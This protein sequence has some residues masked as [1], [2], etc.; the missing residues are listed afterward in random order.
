MKSLIY[1][2]SYKF[3]D[4]SPTCLQTCNCKMYYI[5]HK[6][7]NPLIVVIHLGTD[8]H[9][10]AN[11]KCKESF[12]DMKNMVVYEVCCMLTT[13]ILAI[14]L[15]VSKTFLSY[16][17]FNKGGKGHVELLKGEKLN[18]ILLKFGAFLAYTI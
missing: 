12:Q 17:L 13:I 1:T 16:H 18:Q 3:Y 8:A 5:V 10:I 15:Y 4:F 11:N 6:F 9:P 7:P 2:I 14:T